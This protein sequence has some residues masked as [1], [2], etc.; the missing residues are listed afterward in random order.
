MAV[1]NDDAAL[2]EMRQLLDRTGFRIWS[3]TRADCAYCTGSSRRTVSF[4]RDLVFCHRC[5]WKANRTGLARRLGLLRAN[6][7]TQPRSHE[8]ATLGCLFGGIVLRPHW[9]NSG[10]S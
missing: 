6:R 9:M 2:P 5:H 4:T 10:Q 8:E 1:R 3:A 7:E